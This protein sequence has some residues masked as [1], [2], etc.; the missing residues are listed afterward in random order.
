[1]NMQAERIM[2]RSEQLYEVSRFKS[3]R[4]LHAAWEVHLRAARVNQCTRDMTSGSKS[5]RATGSAP[6]ASRSATGRAR[7]KMV[8]KAVGRAWKSS[9]VSRLIGRR[10]FVPTIQRIAACRN[11]HAATRVAR[12][13]L[14]C[15]NSAAYSPAMAHVRHS[16]PC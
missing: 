13:T 3:L 12:S 8:W 14:R 10:A 11:S 16:R 7:A 1:M 5:C 6:A 9:A 4:N 15:A 2:N